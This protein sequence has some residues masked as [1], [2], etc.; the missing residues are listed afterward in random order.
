M[1]QLKQQQ[2]SAF[3]EIL[4][5]EGLNF[6]VSVAIFQ[7]RYRLGLTQAQLAQRVGC[8]SQMIAAL[9]KGTLDVTLP[10]LEQIAVVTGQHLQ[11]AFEPLD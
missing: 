6:D 3:A 7:L 4:V 1:E 5:Q 2:Q 11:V 10:L 9:E 8:S